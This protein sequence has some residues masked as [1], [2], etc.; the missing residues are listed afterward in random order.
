LDLAALLAIG[1]SV[2]IGGADFVGGL[3]ARKMPAIP[4][5]AAAQT[6][7]LLFLIPI[8]LVGGIGGVAT[9]DL[10]FGAGAGLS[11][12]LAFATF[13]IA[14]G[15][16]PMSIVS[17]ITA[18]VGATSGAALGIALGDRP[19]TLALAGSALG[20]AAIMLVAT[21]RRGGRT[22]L[23]STLILALLAGLGFGGFVVLLDQPAASAG[24]W[25]LVAARVAGVSALLLL[26]LLRSQAQLPRGDL[27]RKAVLV[28]ILETAAMVALLSSLQIGSLAIVAVLSS[29]YPVTTLL[30]A[31]RFLNERLL[32]HQLLGVASALAAIVLIS[33]G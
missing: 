20:V 4:F 6:L 7:N 32:R 26:T 24:V 18:V 30:L 27:A 12:S 22:L 2:C 28:G 29:L 17:P 14:M 25:P 9:R 33:V 16:G 31:R 5:T 8:G 13:L 19:S 11:G 23:T 1:S 21:E 15:R 3:A 10:L